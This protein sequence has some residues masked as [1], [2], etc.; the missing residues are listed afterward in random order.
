MENIDIIDK[1]Y[2]EVSK[3]ENDSRRNDDRRVRLTENS[4]K[5]IDSIAYWNSRRLDERRQKTVERIN[6]IENA[7][8]SGGLDY[9]DSNVMKI[10]LQTLKARELRYSKRI[11]KSCRRALK[12]AAFMENNIIS[13]FVRYIKSKIDVSDINNNAIATMIDR[14]FNNPTPENEATIEEKNE[15]SAINNPEVPAIDVDSFYHMTKDQIIQDDLS[16][17]KVEVPIIEKKEEIDEVYELGN[18]TSEDEIEKP[19]DRGIYETDTEYNDYL[20]GFYGQKNG[21]LNNEN[22]QNNQDLYAMVSKTL[23]NGNTTID[24]LERLRSAL[25]TERNTK[26]QLTRELEE[27]RMEAAVAQK[28]A[29]EAEKEKQAKIRL[30]NDELAAYREENE[31]LKAK[32]KEVVDETQ[33][34]IS[35]RQETM[36][37]IDS[38]N[39]MIGSQAVNVR[40]NENSRG[41]K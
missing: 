6:E 30:V 25:E 3:A 4:K 18:S 32:T 10:E 35:M 14:E 36:N 17:P 7:Q 13:K 27:K 1:D 5:A 28:E 39:Q 33:R 37:Y 38:L 24:D 11:D 41:G 21:M 40:N 2:S 26:S 29:E 19:R 20:N 16:V 9:I 22:N 15:V 12:V 34:K 31:R 8:A 23:V